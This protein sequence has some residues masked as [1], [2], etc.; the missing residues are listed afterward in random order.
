MCGI[1]SRRKAEELVLS[2]R[3]MVNGT[4]VKD[5]VQVNETD[6][7]EVDGKIVRPE[8]FVYYMLNKPAGYITSKR[9]P[10]GRKTIFDL[11]KVENG[12]FPVGRLDMETEGLL[13]LTND[14]EVTQILLH[15][16]HEIDRVYEATVEGQV[17]DEERAALK[18]GIR[19]PYGYTAKMRI[20]TIGSGSGKTD[21]RISIREGRKR[22]IRRAL[23]YLEHQVLSLKRISFG[24]V[25]IDPSL[26]TGEYRSLTAEEVKTLESLKNPNIRK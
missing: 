26:K 23:R 3:V 9:D 6:R 21:L 7:V 19:L 5:Y 18:R 11:L 10:Q 15:P 22:E 16:S 25:R 13:L 20:E 8:V 1:A 2:G 4:A 12:V 14:G 24:P 17:T